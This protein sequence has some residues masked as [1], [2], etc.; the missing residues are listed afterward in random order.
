MVARAQKKRGIL[1]ESCDSRIP[2]QLPLNI[3][4]IG[5]TLGCQDSDGLLVEAGRS[6]HSRKTIKKED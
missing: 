6:S 1:H 2:Q 3:G 5:E 4:R